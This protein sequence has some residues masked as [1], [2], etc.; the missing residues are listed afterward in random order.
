M[1]GYGMSRLVKYIYNSGV[2]SELFTKFSSSTDKSKRS[3]LG[4]TLVVR[5]TIITLVVAALIPSA[6]H[7]AIV[8]DEVQIG[9]YELREGGIVTG[10]GFETNVHGSGLES[11]TV[12]P[13]GKSATD[14]IKDDDAD[15]LDTDTSD[16]TFSTLALLNSSFPNNLT[17][18]YSVIGVT[19]DTLEFSISVNLPSLPSG[20]PDITSPVHLENNVPLN[21]ILEWDCM[22]CSGDHINAA[23]ES[24]DDFEIK[25]QYM[26]VAPGSLNPGPL[27]T[28]TTYIASVTLI[29]EIFIEDALNLGAF[30]IAD[31][32]FN[33]GVDNEIAFTTSTIP[34]P[35]TL[36]LLL[37]GLLGFGLLNR[38]KRR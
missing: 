34:I 16:N 26:D 23:I 35:A 15:T 13:E 1:E 3:Y 33:S 19:G 32:R 2:F 22:A 37:S 4:L 6:L 5:T 38:A 30:G 28:D 31:L 7:A 24:V 9:V 25:Q 21:A 12:T 29:N 20:F 27:D 36:P 17:Y 11:G 14:L 8:I 10:W 18:T